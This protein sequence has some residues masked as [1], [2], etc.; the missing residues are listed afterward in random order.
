MDKKDLRKQ[1]RI[2]KRQFTS[3]QLA[4]MSESIIHNLL[5]TPEMKSANVVLMYYSLDD[6][7]NTHKAIDTLVDEGKEVLFP[8]VVSDTEMEIRRY[9]GPD[10]LRG[11]FFN[12]MEPIGELFTDYEKI[13]VAVVPGM[14][15]DNQGNRLGRGKGY[16]DRFL[17]KIPNATK[18]GICFPFQKFPAIPV[19]E[20]DIKMDIV[21]S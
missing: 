6:E 11:G 9:T 20:N 2:M 15:F 19:A 8:V 5:V 21:L 18:I 3:D 10:D 7:V 14:S 13:D 1:V 12:I 17:P 4:S 16:Y